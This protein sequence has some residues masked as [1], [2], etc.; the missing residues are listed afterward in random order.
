MVKR[1]WHVAGQLA[2]MVQHQRRELV[3]DAVLAGT[4][5]AV[6]AGSAGRGSATRADGFLQHRGLI[7][8]SAGCAM[9]EVAVLTA[10]AP[11][12]RSLAAQVTAPP[13]LAVFHDLRWLFGYNRSWLQFAAG[14]LILLAGRSV[15][16]TIMVELAWPRDLR[17]PRPLRMF[18]VSME[19]TL[20]AALLLVPITTL[21]FGVAVL[22]FSWPFLAAVPVLLAIALPLSHGGLSPA[23]W[24]RLPPPRAAGWMLACFAEYSLLAV[25]ITR[26]PPAGIVAVAGLAG[27]LNARAWYG[28]TAAVARPR[29]R[30]HP[31][32]A[33]IPVAPLVA[34]SVFA[35][36]IGTTRLI[37]DMA[38]SAP[39][40]GLAAAS[41][42]FA[43]AASRAGGLAATVR[44]R[45]RTPAVLVI[46][47]FGSSCCHSFRSLRGTSA[48]T[49]EQFSYLGLS[50]AG[51][52]IPQ[53]RAASDLPMQ[54]LGDMIATQV[55]HL[56]A[57]TGSPV[58]LVA[59]SE[60]SLGVYAMFA[61]HPQVPVG[62]VVLLSPIV[63][64]GQVSFPQAGQQGPGVASGYALSIL[65]RLVGEL[66]PFGAAGAERL[67]DSVSSVGAQYAADDAARVMS[68]RW[69][70][71]VPLADAVTLPA[72]SM[73]QNVLFVP[74]FHG[75]LLGD[76]AVLATVRSFLDGR[77]VSSPPSLREAAQIL[78]A[79][80]A[81][82]RMPVRSA[83]SPPCPA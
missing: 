57:Q 38:G 80:A 62:S 52:P 55:W 3:P 59:E 66:S 19:F 60:G 29:S 51:K 6:T 34:I 47:G 67:I 70:A 39:Q 8:F 21:V 26:V 46:S 23:W 30:P 73:P 28:L 31:L 43:A 25:V 27:V 64:P 24:R 42:G 61:R 79:A 35:L 48:M 13:P 12:A 4:G 50:A 74:A 2:R 78:S 44:D 10:L 11:A 16:N 18:A 7:A 72:C 15:L 17:A 82:W 56:H 75:G 77:E 32:L 68:E 58:D 71:L 5:I 37:F 36:A 63:A 1:L 54:E 9:A 81:A 83:P 69:L 53:G 65:N 76:P 20:V 33:W 49:I 22:P 14:A 45:D 41:A 40:T